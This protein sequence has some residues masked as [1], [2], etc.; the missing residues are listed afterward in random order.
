MAIYKLSATRISKL[1]RQ[2]KKGKYGDGGN[3]WLEVSGVD[4]ASW[5][6]RWK[7]RITKKDR[8]ISYGPW[9]ITDLEQAR[10][11]A[12]ADR[13]LLWADKNPKEER[14]AR[15]LDDQIARGLARTVRQVVD[16][17]DNEIIAHLA[18][19]TQIAKR[20]RCRMINRA[21]GDMPIAKVNRQIILDKVGFADLWSTKHPT[22]VHL[23]VDLAQL[24][25]F[26]IDKGYI[27]TGYNPALMEHLKRS[28][29]KRTHRLHKTKHHDALPYK[30]MGRFMQK[31]RAYR[32]LGRLS[33][34]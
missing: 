25:G 23:Q 24:F 28:L 33:A 5:L 14:N 4:V 10:K 16:E 6:F 11:L 2:G 29:P 13:R 31:L 20:R 15:I 19:N 27:P 18:D 12:E 3:L 1:I 30:D 32:H 17:F 26:A 8:T 22:A 21:I 7:D 9:H 34:I